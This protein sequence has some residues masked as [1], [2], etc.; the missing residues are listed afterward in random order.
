MR[1]TGYI[2]LPSNST[3]GTDNRTTKYR[4]NLDVPIKLEGSYEIAIVEAI[5]TQSWFLN[6][7][8]IE[9]SYADIITNQSWQKI[10]IK[11][12]D[13]ENLVEFCIRINDQIKEFI[14]E[15]IY[16]SRYAFL[17]SL[18]KINNESSRTEI[19]KLNLNYYPSAFFDKV[20]THKNKI[21]VIDDIKKKE[22]EYLEAFSLSIINSKLFIEFK[23]KKQSIKFFG[24]ITRILKN[25]QNEILESHTYAPLNSL[26]KAIND[27]EL[28]DQLDPICLLGTLFIY[29]DI[30][31]YTY[32]GSKMMPLLRTLVIDYKTIGRTLISHFDTPHY[33]KINKEEINSILIDIRDDFGE[34]IYFENSKITIKLHY[35][36]ILE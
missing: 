19:E 5:Y 23:S 4:T 14:V 17:E 10:P 16:N 25:N 6:V 35:R 3:D 18:Y 31:E 1:P 8:Y 20:E 21:S 12:Y 26:K 13:G 24:D 11:F 36:P 15:K 7:G 30:G 29:S 32:Y 2:S 27:I 33:I 9:Y 34:K 28:H 22:N